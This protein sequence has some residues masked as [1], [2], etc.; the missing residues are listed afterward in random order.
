VAW[1]RSDREARL[2][3]AATFQQGLV[4]LPDVERAAD[5]RSNANRRALLLAVAADCAGGS[6]SLGELDLLDLL[7]R[8]RL[9]T[10]SRQSSRRDRRG[11]IRYLDVFFEAWKVAVEVDG[12]HHLDVA[13]AWDDA[14]RSNDLELAGY[15][16]LRFPAHALRDEPDRVIA[17]IRTALRNAG[18]R[19]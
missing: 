12:V 13:Q 4:R 5:E 6:H 16:V 1:A 2:I 18:W 11:R 17:D 8:A 15:V 14:Q 7:R 19:P 9:P 3:V 10:P